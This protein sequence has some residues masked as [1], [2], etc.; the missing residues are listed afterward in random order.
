M[1]N[2]PVKTGQGT[3]DCCSEL[4]KSV[5]LTFLN[6]D[7]VFIVVVMRAISGKNSR[8]HLEVRPISLSS[9]T[10]RSYSSRITLRTDFVA[11]ASFRENEPGV[12]CLFASSY[13]LAWDV[14]EM[15]PNHEKPAVNVNT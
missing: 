11:F 6:S 1:K 4:D 3:P 10:Y 12:E 14:P 9:G 13:L 15:H 7:D 8:A 2:V 5:V